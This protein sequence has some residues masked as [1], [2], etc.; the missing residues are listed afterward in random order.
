[1]PPETKPSRWKV[2]LGYAAFAVFAFILCL[3]LTF[4]YDAVRTRLVTEAAAQGLAVR[5]GSLRPGLSGITAT[6]VSVSKPPAPLSADTVAALARGEN[7]MLGPAELGTALTFDSVAVRPTL[8]PPGLAV[9]L[10]AMG[11]KI[12]IV[13]GGLKTSTLQVDAKGVQLSGG[14]LPAYTGVDME[15]TVNAT[16]VM[17]APGSGLKGDAVD[18]SQGTGTLK[19]DTQGVV[20]KGGKVPIPMGPGP[21]MP[22]DLP[23]IVVGELNGDIQF[24]K[25]LGTVQN[26]QLKSDDLEGSG[27]GTLKLGKR[28]EYSELGMDVKI[29]FDPEFQKRLGPLSIGLAMLPADREDP[30]YRGGRLIGM[31]SSPRFQPKR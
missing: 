19:L 12:S 28:V 23:R 27:T 5:I 16:L 21:A 3:L 17:T 9:N 24:E 10:N 8:F 1:M 11:G 2:V 6:Q 13:S 4:P 15:G 14:N 22:M 30:T 18:W 25:G 29:K 20:I 26:L 7:T 31:L